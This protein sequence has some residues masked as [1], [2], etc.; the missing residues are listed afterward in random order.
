MAGREKTKFFWQEIYTVSISGGRVRVREHY[1]RPRERF[2]PRPLAARPL[3]SRKAWQIGESMSGARRPAAGGR[4]SWA[5]DQ[6]GDLG[7]LQ[8]E[9]Q[10]PGVKIVGIVK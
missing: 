5:C 10:Q 7:V 6:V 1:P 4:A 9:A 8:H 2:P 3:G